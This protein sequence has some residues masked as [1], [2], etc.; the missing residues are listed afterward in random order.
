MFE[1]NFTSSS[2]Q[3]SPEVEPQTTRFHEELLSTIKEHPVATG[4][5]IAGATIATLG[6]LRYGLGKKLLP[7]LIDEIT[8]VT[9]LTSEAAEQA[10]RSSGKLGGK[11][12]IFVLDSSKVPNSQLMR[13]VNTLVPRNLSARIELPTAAN[14]VLERPFPLGPFSGYRYLNGVRN[15]P[16]GSISLETGKF[17][18]NEIF[19]GG[20]FRQATGSE[21]T[22]YKI[23]QYL[24]DYGID[25][26]L[27]LDGAALSAAHG[28]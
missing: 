16:L 12:G 25:A 23:H 18:Q 17:T 6:L 27:A 4:L 22:R 13:T 11:W 8:P 3:R 1:N 26:G 9:H 21:I 7:S 15:S 28:H 20:V 24:L 19:A 14:S 10:I 5:T 2:P